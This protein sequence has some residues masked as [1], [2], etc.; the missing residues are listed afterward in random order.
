VTGQSDAWRALARLLV[1]EPELT[2]DQVAEAAGVGREEARHLWQALGFP[3]VADDERIF[4]RAD[5]EMLATVR[6]IVARG[7]AGPEFVVQIARVIGQ[8]LARVA[9]A[10]SVQ[11]RHAV[12]E[13][14]LLASVEVVPD[15]E[16]VLGYVWR[17]HLLAAVLRAA[18]A[19]ATSGTR[20]V[21]GFADLVGFT[22]I[23]QHLTG[24]E[25]S[26]FVERFEAHA[27]ERIPALGGR[28][29]KTIGDEVMFAAVE[30]RAAAAIALALVD[31]Y[32]HDMQLPDVRVG[33]ASGPTVTFE[34][35]LFGP[36]VN[37]ANRLVTLAR[38]GTILVSEELGAELAGAGT[39]TLRR[40]RPRLKGIGRVNAWVLRAAEERDDAS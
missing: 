13:R 35:D 17:R 18:A 6:R 2:A 39:F 28:I 20:L 36:T 10:Q 4:S 32:A 37:L 21:V 7:A 22:E 33:L 9:E 19:D 14:D 5:V 23:A 29:V 3:P 12:S 11:L 25:L 34:G 31:V 15:L 30:A 40:L 16:R 8:S 1:G 26:D 24:P 38:P 27:Y